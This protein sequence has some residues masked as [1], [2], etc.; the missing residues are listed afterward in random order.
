MPSGLYYSLTWCVY[1]EIRRE[2]R[3]H[4]KSHSYCPVKELIHECMAAETLAA[5]VKSARHGHRVGR[6]ES[7][8]KI[9]HQWGNLIVP[10]MYWLCQEEGKWKIT[11]SWQRW[12]TGLTSCLFVW[13][14]QMASLRDFSSGMP[15]KSHSAPERG[16]FP[17]NVQQSERNIKPGIILDWQF[18]LKTRVCCV[19][20]VARV[21]FLCPDRVVR[22]CPQTFG[23]VV[24]Y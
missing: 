2:K 5:L 10:K 11:A 4:A 15:V 19:T 6:E 22:S 16:L 21:Y 17:T 3:R 8:T 24:F 18:L 14:W 13:A 7:W 23:H 9:T 20:K 12:A 1:Y